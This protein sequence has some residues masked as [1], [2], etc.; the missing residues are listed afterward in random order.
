M[1]SSM[2]G[3]TAGMGRVLHGARRQYDG[4]GCDDG[5]GYVNLHA[6]SGLPCS[7]VQLLQRA[8]EVYGAPV[9]RA[10]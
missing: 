9:L 10:C 5:D 4:D 8:F 2:M 7:K 6:H 3:R 1:V